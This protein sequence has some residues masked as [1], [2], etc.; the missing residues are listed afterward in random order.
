M[1]KNFS[2]QKISNFSVLLLLAAFVATLSGCGSGGASGSSSASGVDG[3]GTLAD[4]VQLLVSSPQMPSSGS[5]PVDLT[6]IVL[7]SNGQVISGKTVTFSRTDPV[8][9]SGRA[10]FNSVNSTSD[11]NGLATAKINLGSNKTNRTISISATAD[12]ATA[13]NSVDVTGT[14]ITISGNASLALDAT[15][16]LTISVKNSAGVAL[17]GVTVTLESLTGN[18]ISPAT[19]T[20]TGVATN[21]SGQVTANVTAS[22]PGDDIIS[23]SAAGTSKTQALTISNA[24]FNFTAP[25]A[26]AGATPEIPLSASSAVSVTWLN[27]SGIA[28]TGSLVNFSATRGTISGSPATTNGS[29]AT[30]GVTISSTSAGPAIITAT[31]PGGTPASTLNVLFVATSASSVTAQ[32]IPS[33]V[34]PST[35]SASQSDNIATISAVVRDGANNLVKNAKINFSIIADVSNGSLSAGTATTDSSGSA[36]VNYIAGNTSSGQNG[37]TV[38]AQ[39]VEISGTPIT[40]VTGTTSLTVGG[41]ALFVRLGTDNTVISNDLTY[42]KKYSAIV[43]D[44]AGNPA[45]A[46]TEVRFVLRPNRYQKGEYLFDT[47]DSVWRKSI[48][49]GGASAVGITCDNEDVNFNGIKDAGEDIN[50]NGSLT[51]GNVADV[52]SPAT[53]DE[54]G[55]ATAEISYSKNYATWT[56]VILE[57]R[58]GVIGDDPPET[59]TFVLPGAADDYSNEN[60]PPPGVES[61]FGRGDPSEMTTNATKW[62]VPENGQLCTNPL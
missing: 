8:S 12:S 50:Q 29:G 22:Q 26:V 49:I 54:F 57:A 53:T 35:G 58:A 55:F 14:T 23:V 1:Q 6:A 19:L 51:P 61:P 40:A 43:T 41:E 11:A 9:S 2:H 28:V 47:V 21:S 59:V 27:A 36:S 30:P 46:G 60:T 45:P 31:G 3:T 16:T 56:E 39:A 52:I 17:Q 18:T 42:T 34:K 15:T 10:Y 37:V 7:D 32:A 44:S 24:S 38:Q 5:T 33:I 20:T 13:T 62:P 4:T 48:V 25:S